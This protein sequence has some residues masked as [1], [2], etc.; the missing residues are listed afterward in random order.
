[1]VPF[2]G[3]IDRPSSFI[4][5]IHHPR[6]H[7]HKTKPHSAGSESKARIVLSKGAPEV[8]LGLCSHWMAADGKAKKMDAAK[9]KEADHWC[10]EFSE[11]V[12]ICV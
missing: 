10:G 3:L 9:L 8:L 2:N 6:P 11:Q 1:M 4:Y 7:H 12:C 5:S